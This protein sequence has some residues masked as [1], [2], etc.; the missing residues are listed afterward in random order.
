MN[1][2]DFNM[3]SDISLY[4]KLTTQVAQAPLETVNMTLCYS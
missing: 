1:L 4:H 3:N 2:K